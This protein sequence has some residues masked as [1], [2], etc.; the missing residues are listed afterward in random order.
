MKIALLVSMSALFLVASQASSSDDTATKPLAKEET[1]LLVNALCD[2]AGFYLAG[3]SLAETA[4]RPATAEKMK[5]LANGAEFSAQFLLA[6]EHARTHAEPRTYGSF[7]S[8]TQGRVESER[9]NVLATMEGEN[10]DEFNKKLD[11]CKKLQPLQE[12][13]VQRVRDGSVGR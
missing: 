12:D 8:Y 2:C 7:S 10:K 9:I 3:M 1:T 6:E 13:I 5:T 11:A 4:D